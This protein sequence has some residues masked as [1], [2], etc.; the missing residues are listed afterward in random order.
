MKTNYTLHLTLASGIL[1]SGCLFQGKDESMASARFEIKTAASSALAKGSAAGDLV[2]G[3]STGVRITLNEALLN[4]K[5]I[6]LGEDSKEDTCGDGLP[7][8][9][10]STKSKDDEDCVDKSDK[11]FKGGPYIVNLLTGVSTPDI[12]TIAVPAG[13]YNRVKIHIHQPDGKDAGLMQDQTFLAKGTYSNMGG[14]E[15]PFTLSLKFNEVIHIRSTAGMDLDAE[16]LN[17]ILV[18]LNAGTWLANLNLK[19]CL[20][21][22]DMS[23]GG[24]IVVTEDS[25]FGKCLDAEHVL[26]DNFRGSFK[27]NKK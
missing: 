4:I 2:L 21:T 9:G 23:A 8:L 1:L 27:I 25:P 15:M 10:D 24:A 20:S 11:T 6:H 3:D 17:T 22:L 14:V 12:G 7:K 13:S 5:K 26:K 18:G 16:A 19:G